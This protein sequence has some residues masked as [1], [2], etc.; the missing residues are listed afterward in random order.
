LAEKLAE[1]DE[2]WEFYRQLHEENPQDGIVL[3]A[4]AR[5][6]SA[7]GETALAIQYLEGLSSVAPDHVTRARYLRRIAEAHQKGGEP[8]KARAAYHQA[9]D[10]EPEDRQSLAGLKSLTRE[11]E[12]WSELVRVL[13]REASVESGETQLACYREIARLWEEKLNKPLV[14][15]DAWQKVLEFAPEDV[16]ACAALVALCRAGKDW[17]GLLLHGQMLLKLGEGGSELQA[18]LGCLCLDQL[19][20]LKK[21]LSLLTGAMRADTPSIEAAVRLENY[22]LARGGYELAVDA[23]RGQARASEGAT[24]VG[25]L[26]RA[27]QIL[28]DTLRNRDAAADIF[29]EILSED[30]SQLEAIRFRADYLFERSEFSGAIDAFGRMHEFESQ[31]DLEDFDDRMEVA[32]Y[33]FR[34]GDALRQVGKHQEASVRY[35]EALKA[36]PNH[37]PSL[38]ALGPLLVEEEKWEEARDCYRQLLQ[39][40]GGQGEPA[41][42]GEIYGTLG[43][44]ELAL[45]NYERAR[46]RIGKAL[47]FLPDDVRVLQA[48]ADVVFQCSEWHN[49][50]GYYNKII[51]KAGQPEQV[52][53]AFLMKSYVLDSK[54]E[55]TEKASQHYLKSLAFDGR[56]PKVLLRLAEMAIRDK[57][58]AR[59]MNYAGRG[60]ELEPEDTVVLAGLH[61]ACSI[62]SFGNGDIS[63]GE[64]SLDSVWAAD[65][66]LRIP[67]LEAPERTVDTMA[68]ALHERLK[69]RP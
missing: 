67:S 36:N 12:E 29:S 49:V 48:M 35:R 21:G 2:A 43:R 63:S 51:A 11:A 65:A 20:Q 24:R 40:T 64:V 53:R 23:I 22:H 16:E 27:A 33:F 13:A 4:L 62:A 54:L 34:F 55:L 3:E 9:L 14:S 52:I 56:Q 37:L 18:E 59:A 17:E 6:A 45:G 60:L 10:L 8:Q 32:L 5:I 66:S 68:K 61:L 46:K 42:L 19:Q 26:L 38:D 15:V 57:D 25:H 7:R 58:W 39:L 69:L 1:T 47:E 28:R 31:R 30:E 44:V 50:L 41:R